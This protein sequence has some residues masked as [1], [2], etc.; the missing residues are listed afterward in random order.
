[1]ND[2]NKS[3]E[4]ERR[5]YLYENNKEEYKRERKKFVRGVSKTFRDI[6]EE[7]KKEMELL[8]EQTKLAYE[9]EESREN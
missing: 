8:E 3:K 9:L 4:K 6:R 5:R 1:M 2:R 7:K